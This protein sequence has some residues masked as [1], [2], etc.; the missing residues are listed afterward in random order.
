MESSSKSTPNVDQDDETVGSAA[1]RTVGRL[2]ERLGASVRA[3]V[4]YGEPVERGDVTVIPVARARWGFG[5]GGGRNRRDEPGAGGGGGAM[6]TPIGYIEIR[7]D[8]TTR[9]RRIVA[10]ADLAAIVGLSLIASLVAARVMR[11]G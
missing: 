10:T 4:I 3:S 9:F 7:G 5:G 2:A 1:E 6:V 11:S 8:G